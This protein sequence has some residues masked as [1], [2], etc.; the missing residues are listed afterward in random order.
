[1]IICN[2]K[3]CHNSY[4]RI[5]EIIILNDIR[6]NTATSFFLSVVDL[7]LKSFHKQACSCVLNQLWNIYSISQWITGIL[8]HRKDKLTIVILTASRLS[9][10]VVVSMQF[11]SILSKISRQE[12]DISDSVVFLISSSSVYIKWTCLWKWGLI[13]RRLSTYISECM[14]GGHC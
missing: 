12:A 10:N 5:C 11:E 6:Y 7:A 9:I 1:V 13:D 14:V 4:R 8:L 2:R 3:Q